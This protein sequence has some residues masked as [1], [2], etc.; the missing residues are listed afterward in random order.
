MTGKPRWTGS[1]RTPDACLRA[2]TPTA[3]EVARFAPAL[4]AFYN[5]AYNREMMSN[6]VAMSP[7]EVVEHFQS[8]RAAGGLPFLLEHDGEL[9]GDADFRHLV[10]ME[11]LEGFPSLPAMVRGRQSRPAPHATDMETLEGFPSL[12]AMVRGR[13]SRPA[14]H[15]TGRTAEFAILI[16]RRPQQ[17]RGWGTRFALLLHALAFGQPGLGLERV[18]VSIIPANLPSQRLFAKLGY[19]PDR[20]PTARAFA[21]A[22]SDLTLS[23][24]RDAFASLHASALPEMVWTEACAP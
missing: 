19:Q 3:Q 9:A 10:D 20:S 7:D 24:G 11:T 5:D 21:E 18:F 1:W 15:A 23:L 22:D 13:Q 2:Y 4:A 6:T 17:S 12:P 16:G 14:P 8:V